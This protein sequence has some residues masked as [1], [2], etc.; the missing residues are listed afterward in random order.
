VEEKGEHAPASFELRQNYPN[1]FNPVTSIQFSV[2]A[3]SGSSVQVSLK[4]YDVLGNEV[5]TLVNE[6]KPAG[7]YRVRFAATG[8]A[9]GIYFYQLKAGDPSTSPGQGLVATKKM[10]VVQ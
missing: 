8:L 5:A 1:P 9:S 4:V 10:I 2:G 7:T 6:K 3:N